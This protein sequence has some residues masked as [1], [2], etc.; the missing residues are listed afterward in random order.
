MTTIEIAK[1]V[2]QRRF[3]ELPTPDPGSVSALD[4]AHPAILQNTTMFELSVVAAKDAP[5]VLV[6][7]QNNR[8]IGKVV[9]KG[10]WKGMPIYALTLVERMTCPSSCYL[11]KECYGNAMPFARRHLPGPDLE[12]RIRT[13][14]RSL[15]GLHPQGFVVRLH[16]LGDFYSVAY[17][18]MWADL[19][20]STKQ[21]HV[22]GY[23]A[24]GGSPEHVEICIVIDAINDVYGTRA[25]IRQSSSEA[26]PGG[27]TVIAYEPEKP[28]VPEGVVCPA[29]RDATACCATCGMCWE[30]AARNRTVVFLKHGLGSKSNRAVAGRANS[31]PAGDLRPVAPIPDLSETSGA[32]GNLPPRLLWV[33]PRQLLIDTSYQRD[34]T[35]ASIRLISKIVA[36]WNWTGI[37]AQTPVACGAVLAHLSV[38]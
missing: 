38:N 10:A 18:E 2:R 1:D 37:M 33:E 35:Q 4:D 31:V 25:F 15:A 27:T 34:L 13:E 11:L 20:R 8:K 9:T 12:E 16:V 28:T 5:R 36:N 32:V 7:G 24:L 14:V 22:Y 29:E 19:L 6:S 30:E 23:T 21:L 17:A 26:I 3:E